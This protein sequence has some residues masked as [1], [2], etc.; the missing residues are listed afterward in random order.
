MDTKLISVF[1]AFFVAPRDKSV[2]QQF[3]YCGIIYNSQGYN[4]RPMRAVNCYKFNLFIEINYTIAR[5]GLAR[6]QS[7]RVQTNAKL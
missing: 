1:F 3:L 5:L 2:S 7:D 6:P 4:L